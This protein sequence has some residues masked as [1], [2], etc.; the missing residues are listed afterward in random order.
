MGQTEV[1]PAVRTAV[2]A[3][4]GVLVVGLL[5]LGVVRYLEEQRALT[6]VPTAAGASAAEGGLQ[7]A[8]EAAPAESEPVLAVHVAGAVARPGVY[9][10]A[11]GARV[12]EVLEA[13]GGPLPEAAPHVL[14]LAA[15]VVDGEKIYVPT[16]A[17]AEAQAQNGLSPAAQGAAQG[18]SGSGSGLVSINRATAEELEQVKGIGPAIAQAIV[19]YRTQHGPFQ[20]LEDLEAVP[21]IGPRTLEKLKPY[22][23]L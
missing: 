15:R 6:V 17:E 4:I 14:N 2:W 18:L 5:G 13:A 7:L 16:A 1:S 23:C 21:G 10:L 9:R 19:E 8:Q 3:F 11:E 12:E 20:Q 22:L